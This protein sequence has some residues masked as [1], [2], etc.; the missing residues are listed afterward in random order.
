MSIEITNINEF[1]GDIENYEEDRLE[2]I[3]NGLELGGQ[4]IV[5]EAKTRVHVV[6][7][8]LRDSIDYNTDDYK[9]NVYASAKHAIYEEYGTKYRP[10]HPFLEVSIEVTK[11]DIIKIMKSALGGK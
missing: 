2:A 5:K 8:K 9:L 11:N 6:T 4:M 10:P 3:K 7:G 1:I